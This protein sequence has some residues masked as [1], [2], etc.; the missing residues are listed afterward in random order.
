VAQLSF[1]G[2][3]AYR[4][5]PALQQAFAAITKIRANRSAV[6]SVAD[7]LRQA[8]RHAR[9]GE[10]RAIDRSW[11]GRPR[12]EIRLNAVT[13]HHT[14]DRPAAVQGL[15][16]CIPAGATVGVVGANGSGKTTLVDLLTGLLAPDAG[17][18][19]VDGIVLDD[20]NRGAWQATIAYVPQHV[21]LL[22]TTLAQNI[23]LGT[24]AEQI[25]RERMR[26]AVRLARLEECV[27]AL[28]GGYDEVLGERGAR[29]SGGQRQ[30]LAIAR[31][32]YRQA[33]LLILDEAT[34]AL[35]G[36]AE[37]QVVDMLH[38]LRPT[39]T[40]VLIAHRMSA[41]RHCDVIHE[42]A[43]GRLVRSGTYADLGPDRIRA[44][45][46]AQRKIQKAK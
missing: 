14:A 4:L 20:T 15:S 24:P 43:N 8:L 23:A 3:A 18:I 34:S 25:D 17:N 6:E 46:A 42:L 7:D 28:P 31:A 37:E 11:Q 44:I 41:L 9:R 19:E 13:F 36:A 22:D 16:L 45:G 21:F 30:R 1:F 35:D 27:V 10:T 40:V 38:D 39:C 29:L 12:R 33:S 26:A 2:L 5:L 32:L